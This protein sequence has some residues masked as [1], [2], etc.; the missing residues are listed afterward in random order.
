MEDIN[1]EELDP[2]I[3]KLVTLLRNYNFETVD[4]GDGESKV[5]TDGEGCMH[6]YPNVVIEVKKE[7]LI[8]SCIN[9]KQVLESHGI[10]FPE[11]P[12]AKQVGDDWSTGWEVYSPAIDG[13]YD[14]ISDKAYI[15]LSNVSD[16][17]LK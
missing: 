1:Y 6:K 17:D 13:S 11:Q 14:P 4:S 12:D 5:G 16:K 7:H 10:V 8:Y 2:G 9:L 15:L 3:R